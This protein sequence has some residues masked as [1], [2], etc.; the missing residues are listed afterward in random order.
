MQ[1]IEGKTMIKLYLCI[2]LC[3]ERINNNNDMIAKI[4]ELLQEV[5]A[6]KPLMPRNW[7]HCESSTSAR[8]EP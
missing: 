1:A 4:N 8:K 6:L 5:E 2:V 7:K 3:I